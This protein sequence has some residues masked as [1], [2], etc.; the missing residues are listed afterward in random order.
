[1]ER[2]VQR[3]L[4]KKIIKKVEEFGGV[5]IPEDWQQYERSGLIPSFDKG[6]HKERSIVNDTRRGGHKKHWNK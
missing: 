3:E 5:E 1:M 6:G 2:Y 4:P